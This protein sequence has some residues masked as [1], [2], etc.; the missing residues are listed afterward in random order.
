MTPSTTGWNNAKYRA[1]VTNTS[2]GCSVTSN[3]VTFTVN[4]LPTITTQPVSRTVC[5]NSPA[6]FSVTPSGTGPFTYQWQYSTNGTTWT[7]LTLGNITNTSGSYTGAGSATLSMTPINLEWNNS[8][9]RVIVKNSNN[10]EVTSSIVDFKVNALPTIATQPVSP[11][12]CVGTPTTFSVTPSGTGPFT[13][14]W[15]YSENGT[16][17]LNISTSNTTD[18]AGSYSGAGTATMT[19]TPSTTGW[20]NA[21]YRAVVTNTSTGCSVTSNV[22]TFTVNALPTIA[23]QPV[24]RTVCVGNTAVFSVTPSGTGPFT[25]QWQHSTN[26]TTWTD[27]TLGNIT[28]ASGSYTGAGSSTLSMTPINLD[29][30]NAKYRAIVTN[31]STGCSVTSDAATL[32]VVAPPTIVSPPL[33]QNIVL[34]DTATFSVTVSGT[35][36]FTYQWQS[37][38]NNGASWNNLST[39][40][41]T[42]ANGKYSGAAT[43]TLS[44]IP[45]D[46]T[47][48]SNQYRV[49]VSNGITNC[50]VTSTNV[51]LK[52]MLLPD[53]TPAQFFTDA[54]L[55]VSETT[56]YVVAISNVGSFETTAPF[57]FRVTNFGSAT[58]LTITLNPESSVEIDGDV[59]NLS[60]SDF[61][62]VTSSTRFTF[63]SK[64][65]VSLP[66]NGVKFIGFKITRRGGSNGTNN[67]TVT[68]TNG[69]GGGETPVD[70][71]SISNLINKN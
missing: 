71:N 34:G 29:W 55:S 62:V 4:A 10:C 37:S 21:K 3:V 5:V 39:A 64:A 56:D 35:G 30:D 32:G 54:Q 53:L 25:Y 6:T 28:N 70:N 61:D 51:P 9:I 26:G 42:T 44:L 46:T 38:N 1:V 7:N 65:G 20:N 68:I 17:W 48:S 2:T 50:S 24:S 57:E 59:F 58:G 69:T 36:P 60:N 12:A 43:A 22:V 11:T 33:A 15:Q 40:A 47:W 19:M 41:T 8:K 14:R 52:V 67:N 18:A 31:T 49:I 66:I 63:T 45:Q 16:N 27:L 23:T 13:Y